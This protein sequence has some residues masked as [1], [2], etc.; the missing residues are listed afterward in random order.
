MKIETLDRQ[1]AN[2]IDTKIF[3]YNFRDF[4]HSLVMRSTEKF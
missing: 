1:I 4:I 3:L 2:R